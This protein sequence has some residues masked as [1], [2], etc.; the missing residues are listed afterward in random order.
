MAGI[1]LASLV[2]IAAAV[3]GLSALIATSATA[4]TL[5]KLAGAAYLVFLGVQTLL[6]RGEAKNTSG[7]QGGLSHR[8]VF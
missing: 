2:H 5:V 1:H 4:F 3:A 8:R 7:L 6:G